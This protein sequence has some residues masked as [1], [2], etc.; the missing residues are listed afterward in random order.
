MADIQL[1]VPYKSVITGQGKLLAWALWPVWVLLAPLCILVTLAAI[2]IYPAIFAPMTT[3][4]LLAVPALI[5][6]AGAIYTAVA[7]DDS[8]HLS[9]EGV[10]FPRLLM[11]RVGF[12]K[13]VPWDRL[14]AADI[15]QNGQETRLRLVL[16]GTGAV[17]LPLAGIDEGQIEQMLLAIE[18]WADKCE[19]APQLVAYQLEVQNAVKGIERVSYTQM[20]E[21][22]LASRFT[23]TTF[24]PLE[25]G[26]TIHGGRL[27]IIRQ[28]SFGGFSAIYLARNESGAFVVAKEAV[29]PSGA[30]EK[31][32]EHFDR[33]AKILSGLSHP[34]IAKVFDHFR[35][36]DRNYIVLEYIEGQNLRQYV[37]QH[38]V[39]P[40]DAVRKWMTELA[41]ILDYLHAREPAIVH[42]DLSPDNVMIAADGRLVLIDFGA[43]NYFV[44]QAMGT[45]VGKQAYMPPEQ[46]RGAATVLSDYYSFGG[47]IAFL[48]TGHDPVPL[49]E[50]RPR[51]FNKDVPEDL[52][53]L[54][55]SL[56]K[57][58]AA[59]RAPH[60]ATLR[61]L[62]SI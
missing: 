33:E 41:A 1:S 27:K 23:P 43:A 38:G 62:V 8:V 36:Q 16:R 7:Q 10:Y 44:Q 21:Q 50:S 19:M 55:A 29:L 5:M 14:A 52:D 26:S 9:K 15:R 59:E 61:D 18:L 58:D 46:L 32:Q 25:P 57:F 24:I 49:S 45:L 30:R 28:L 20:W 34:G 35:E 39:P 22:E 47:T 13:Y 31:A 53:R 42:R 60:G 11:P 4:A 3:I 6:A 12:A 54:I 56:T 2:A 17:D 48:L 51:Q 37:N 40:I